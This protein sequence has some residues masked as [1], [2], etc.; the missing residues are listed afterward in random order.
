[1]LIKNIKK[2]YK[3]SKGQYHRDDG[4]AIEYKNGDK[5]WFK[6]DKRHR[7]GGPALERVN[8]IKVWFEDGRYHRLDGPAIEWEWESKNWY[9]LDRPLKEKD[10]N[11]WMNRI[12]KFI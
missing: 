1:M 3:N 10:F 5:E 9:I 4:P 7:I 2:I 8:G 6:E 12:K 11:S